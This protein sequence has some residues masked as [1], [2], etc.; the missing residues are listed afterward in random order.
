MAS[1][2][3]RSRLVRQSTS[4]S[5]VLYENVGII[6]HACLLV[7]IAKYSRPCTPACVCK[8]KERLKYIDCHTP[9]SRHT[10][11][12]TL[13]SSLLLPLLR[14]VVHEYL[15]WLGVRVIVI[16]VVVII[17]GEKAIMIRPVVLRV[18]VRC[19]LDILFDIYVPSS[20][21]CGSALRFPIAFSLGIAGA[22]SPSWKSSSSG[23]PCAS[24]P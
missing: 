4:Q 12:V 16:S 11:L 15:L 17:Q 19:E 5:L 3:I 10:Q 1:R 8:E 23:L 14:C 13:Q 7:A 18:R 24:D 22:K 20:S 2:T 9:P 21:G 6:I